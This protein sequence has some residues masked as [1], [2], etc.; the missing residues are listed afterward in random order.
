MH[1]S[2]WEGEIGYTDIAGGLGVGGDGNM[3]DQVAGGDRR[4]GTGK[5]NCNG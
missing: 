1:E 3:R 4:R 5:Y 2:I